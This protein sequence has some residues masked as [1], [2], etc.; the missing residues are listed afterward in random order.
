M[1]NVIVRDDARCDGCGACVR[2]CPQLVYEQAKPKTT[3]A[4]ATPERCFGCLACEEDCPHG[5]LR[6]H[7]L[8]RDMTRDTV[9]APGTGLD[10]ERTYDLVVVGAGPAGL[11]AAIRARML[12][13]SVAVIER[14]P[15]PARSHHPDGGLLFIPP[16][17]YR[18]TDGPDGLHL[19]DID[20]AFP[21]E[22]VRERL[23]DFMFMGP[24]GQSTRARDRDWKG[25][26]L[27]SKDAFVECLAHR[28]LERGAVIAY[29]TRATGLERKDGG[30]VTGIET[31]AGLTLRGRVTI[32]AEGVTGRLAAKAGVPL[33]ERPVCWAFA[34]EADLPPLAKPTDEAG[35]FVDAA[36]PDKR[37]PAGVGYW[38][39]GPTV[40]HVAWG[41]MQKGKA[42][43]LARPVSE[44]LV[45]L[46][47]KDPR[48]HARLGEPL[49]V[50][51]D[52]IDGCRVFGRRMPGTSVGDGLIAAGD[53][54]TTC[55]MMTNVVAL[56]SGD[57]AAQVAAE[58][59]QRNDVSTASLR[60][61]DARVRK[62]Q[63][64]KGM[65]WM[66]NLLLQAPFELRADKLNQL[67]DKL[68]TLRLGKMMG[69]GVAEVILFYL[70]NTFFLMRRKDL[71]PYLVP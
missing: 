13:L 44:L 1:N 3:P 33:N 46:A 56:R 64:I 17:A 61:Y 52:S 51:P 34:A 36:D 41:P 20:L 25:F 39:S 16:D 14:L 27:V 11:G 59:L 31:D 71:R 2:N 37:L 45:E 66:H 26:P 53:A 8:P 15:S 42:R 30:P 55:G 40:T 69:G 70:R 49:T 60:A 18:S 62:I 4:I 43:V 28:A 57:L 58:A 19:D 22:L 29:N 48:V 32:S 23:H 38:S 67:Y 47:A 63:M 5:A 21:K 7:R 9:P 6:V 10:G 68:G 65:G 35:F 24:R 50:D 54:F 12:G